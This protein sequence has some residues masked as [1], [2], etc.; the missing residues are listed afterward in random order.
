MGAR[1]SAVTLAFVL[2]VPSSPAWADRHRADMAFAPYAYARESTLSGSVRCCYSFSLPVARG[3]HLS[4][5]YTGGDVE[6]TRGSGAEETKVGIN[7]RAGVGVRY[8]FSNKVLKLP[9]DLYPYVQAVS[10]RVRVRETKV[11][12]GEF[13]SRKARNLLLSG[14]LEWEFHPHV[15]I[16]LQGNVLFADFT[17]RSKA[18]YGFTTGVVLGWELPE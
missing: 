18:V 15:S 17:A 4:V 6:G 12:T 1:R 16:R 8:T 9:K 2:A 14:G 7:L 3:L 10:A 11:A 5:V 13:A